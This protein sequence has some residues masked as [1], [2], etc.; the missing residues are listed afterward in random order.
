MKMKKCVVLLS[1]G[2]D[3]ATVLNLAKKRGFF[4][5][6]LIFDYNQRHRKEIECAKTLAK[7]AKAPYKI[8]RMPFPWKGSSLIDRKNGIPNNR[9]LKEIK[10]GIPSTYVPARNLIFL[11]MASGFAESIKARAIFIGAHSE[12]YSG[13]PD[14]RKEFF[15]AFKAV[16][17]KGTKSGSSIKV[18]AP[19]LNK[20]KKD[21]IKT[22]LELSVPLENTW[23]CY[24]GG[25]NP[26]GACDSCFFR[27]RAFKEL[28]MKDPYYERS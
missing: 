21:I 13:Y 2:I 12:D 20:N 24:K 1:G 10:S 15:E 7:K 17:K 26:C 25:K 16:L 22:A 8:I 27:R 18:H 3:S 6:A 5:H 4:P 11:S 28:G 9:T 23:S 14:C 19:L